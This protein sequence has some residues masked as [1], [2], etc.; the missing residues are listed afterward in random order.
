MQDKVKVRCPL[1]AMKACGGVVVQLRPFLTSV[2]DGNDR[3]VAVLSPWNVNPVPPEPIYIS[4]ALKI[5][6]RLSE[7]L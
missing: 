6:F 2:L 3:T 5:S 4:A 7:L 1:Y